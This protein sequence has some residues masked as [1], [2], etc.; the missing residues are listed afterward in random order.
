ME[1]EG[2]LLYSQVP[3]TCPYPEPARSSPY[4]PLPED[5]SNTHYSDHKLNPWSWVFLVN[6]I[7]KFAT[8]YVTRRF[9]TVLTKARHLFLSRATSIQ[10]SPPSYFLNVHI[11]ILIP[12]TP[13]SFMCY[14]PLM[15]FP[16]NPVCTST[17]YHACFLPHPTNASRL[18]H[19]N[20]VWWR[21]KVFSRCIIP[22]HLQIPSTDK[23]L[24]AEE[25]YLFTLFR[26]TS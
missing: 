13:R 23:A 26:K 12:S 20:N 11:N 8:F 5:P 17:L 21:V 16:Q 7:T 15:F 25:H 18:H 6:L 1:P 19:Q 10:S 14:L 9:I 3:A 4:P 22:S 2:S 24:L